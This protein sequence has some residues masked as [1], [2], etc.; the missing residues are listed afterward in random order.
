MLRLNTFGGLTLQQDGEA[1]LGPA[2]Q[3]RRLALLAVV[4]A[5]GKR[6][7]TREKLT[8]LLWPASEPEAARHSLYQA[9]HT[10]R[11]SFTGAEVFLGAASLQ[12]NPELI[13]SDVAEFDDA[14][15]RGMH[16]RAARLYRGTFLDGF[17]IEEAREFE[18]WQ[19]AERVRLARE[20]A[21]AVELLAA[22]ATARADSLG[23]VQWWRRLASAEPVSTRAAVGLIEA[24]AAAGDRVGALQFASVHAALVRQQLE[25]EPDAAVQSWIARLQAGET[26]APASPS[27]GRPPSGAAPA[28]DT[29]VAQATAELRRALGERYEVREPT[30]EGTLLLSFKARDR[31][32]TR[33][34]DLHV[35]NPRFA[36]RG[37]A[38]RAVAVLERAAALHDPRIVS[39]R[40]CGVLQGLLYFATLPRTE[41]TLRDRLARER[42][43]PL[44]DA[45][46]I[47]TDLADVL[48]HAHGRG[49][50]HGDLRPKHV[51]LTAAGPALTG[52]GVVEALDLT[53]AG[54]G[55]TAVS[56]GAPAYL[57]PEQLAGDAPAG[58]RGDLY[59][60]GCILYEMLAGEP[61]FSGSSLAA[62]LSRKL[63]Q[64]AP[65]VKSQRESVPPALDVLVARCLARLPADRYRSASAV[66]DA[67][68]AIEPQVGAAYAE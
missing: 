24:L 16:E 31:R 20:F 58:E 62:V 43:L 23:A 65:S 66:R 15:E 1:H 40:D 27:A 30:A 5:A 35:L 45:L 54:N 3:R 7:V 49:V 4:A 36:G 64:S 47:A 63:T 26:V 67:L 18:E 38:D 6:G 52:F 33:L 42:P 50:W 37:G 39:V 19:G 48:A 68:R 60:L 55:S 13:T 34:V 21:T 2:A 59:A 46:R 44:G 51:L 14:I 25:T 29:A 28:R 12:L 56:V 57:S 53:A 32:D 22:A 41:P 8:E 17:R 11:R 10:I 9:L 61:P